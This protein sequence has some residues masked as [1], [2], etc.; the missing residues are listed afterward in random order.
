MADDDNIIPFQPRPQGGNTPPKRSPLTPP[1]QPPPPPMF[2]IPPATK[3]LAGSL[4]S[5][6]VLIA[7]LSLTLLPQAANI[8]ASFA[9]FVP[10]QWTGHAPFFWWTPLSLIAFSFLH[11][12]WLHLLVN[13]LM[14]V[15]MGSGLEKSVGARR[16]ILIYLGSTIF[17]MLSHLAFYPASTEPVIGASGGVSGIFGAMLFLMYGGDSANPKTSRNNF[18]PAL[19]RVV[20]V[21]IGLSVLLGLMGGPSGEPIAWVAHVGGF[22]A[23]IGIIKM[24]SDRQTH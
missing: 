17:A 18:N 13:T 4:V 5:I 8:A 3:Y 23:G 15:A 2:N 10:A 9:G 20:L 12:G 19:I 22:L 24:L 1:P 6:H 16:Y 21:W 14:L 7:V 11:N